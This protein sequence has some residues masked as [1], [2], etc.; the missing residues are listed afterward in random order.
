VLSAEYG[1]G[2][3]DGKFCAH[4]LVEALLED[5]HGD[6]SPE[7]PCAPASAWPTTRSTSR[8]C[9]TRSPPWPM[10]APP[11]TTTSPRRAGR[12][13]DPRDLTLPRPW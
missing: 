10:R 6:D 2:V 13:D 1:I 3:R 9:C 4:L 12:Q 11:S 8:V 7:P 5:A